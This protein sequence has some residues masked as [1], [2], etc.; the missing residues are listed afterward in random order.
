MPCERCGAPTEEHGV[1]DGFYS[2]QYWHCLNGHDG[3]SNGVALALPHV[4][5]NERP[6][7]SRVKPCRLGCGRLASTEDAQYC[8]EC[9]QSEAVCGHCRK[10]KRNGHGPCKTHAGLDK[11]AWERKRY[12]RLKASGKLQYERER[13][14]R[15]R[16]GRRGLFPTLPVAVPELVEA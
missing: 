1:T 16:E 11:K 6:G 8:D 7:G 14:R 3:Y 12:L 13:N 15:W 2:M 10:T 5:K 4:P 9:R